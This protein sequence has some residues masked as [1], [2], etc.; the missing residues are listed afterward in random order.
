MKPWMWFALLLA[1][2]LFLFNLHEVPL[3]SVMSARY[4][5]ARALNS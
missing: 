1:V 4:E 2:V 3:S 5:L